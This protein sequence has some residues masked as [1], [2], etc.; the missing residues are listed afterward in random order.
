MTGHQDHA[1]TG[2]TLKGEE[3]YSINIATLCKAIGVQNIFEIDSFDIE[4]LE[5][6]LKNCVNGSELT[7]IV[8]K[9]PCA[10]LKGQKF[11]NICIADNEKCKKCGMCLK[12]GCP[13]ITKNA[14]GTINIDKTMCNGCGLCAKYCKF[15]AINKVE[16]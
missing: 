15:D 14:D 11:P 10:L 2:K 13:A 8:A 7:V 9:A 16:R 1:G 3:T 6:T 12:I 5:K 4:T